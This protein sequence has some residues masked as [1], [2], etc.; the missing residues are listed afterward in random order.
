MKN[1]STLLP[2]EGKAAFGVEDN[3]EKAKKFVIDQLSSRCQF[4]KNTEDVHD[5]VSSNGNPS[6]TESLLNFL[7][8]KVADHASK[9]N[10]L[11]NANIMLRQYLELPYE[12]RRKCPLSF[13]KSKECVMEELSILAKKYLSIPAT[14]VPSE[15]VFSKAGQIMNERRNRING[16]NLDMLIFLNMNI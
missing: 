1:R 8:S 14:S 2:K 4:H 9:A 5:T 13:W 6:A 3:A 12:D 11:S 10:P 7:D 15:R 16:K